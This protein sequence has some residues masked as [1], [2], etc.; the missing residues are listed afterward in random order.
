M[1]IGERIVKNTSFFFSKDF[2]CVIQSVPNTATSIEKTTT[3]TK[4][5]KYLQFSFV[6]L[7]EHLTDKMENK[8]L[9]V[10]KIL[11]PKLLLN[12]TKR[13]MFNYALSTSAKTNLIPNRCF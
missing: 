1:M 5:Q 2:N 9:L 12:R 10:V 3:T 13:V 7:T 11:E 6:C 4:M 8:M